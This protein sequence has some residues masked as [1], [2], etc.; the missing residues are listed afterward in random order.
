MMVRSSCT[1]STDFLNFLWRKTY[2][3]LKVCGKQMSFWASCQPLYREYK[4]VPR[5][6]CFIYSRPP[7]ESD[8]GELQKS[9]TVLTTTCEENFTFHKHWLAK[10]WDS[11]FFSVLW[12]VTRICFF[13]Y[14]TRASLL[15]GASILHD[16]PH[17]NSKR[18][19]SR[20]VWGH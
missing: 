17:G 1:S 8:K 16:T 13:V 4:R 18:C 10:C 14:Q 6:H 15:L 5:K 20:D 12:N 11:F 19:R 3:P 2:F 9:F 7:A